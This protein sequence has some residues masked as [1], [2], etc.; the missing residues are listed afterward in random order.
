VTPQDVSIAIPTYKRES[1]L[2]S[3]IELLL[4]Q[5]PAELLIIDQTPE[6]QPPVEAALRHL[7]ATD[8]IRWLRLPRPSITRAMNTA[9][10]RAERP[11]VLFLD[12][13]VVPAPGLIHAHAS[14]YSSDE[15]WG[16]AG[17]VLQPGQEPEDVSYTTSDALG[18]SLGFPFNSTRPTFVRNGMAGNLSLRRER[19]LSVGGFDE[20]FAGVAYRYETEFC[21]RLCRAGGRIFFQPSA[22][23]RHLKFPSGGTRSYGD[24][25]TSPSPAHGV[26]DYYFA[27]RQGPSLSVIGYVLRRPLREVCT[28]FHLRHPWWMPVKLLGEMS[29]LLWAVVLVLRGPRYVETLSV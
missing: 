18:T 24:H 26:G 19:A 21:G 9:L 17:Q 20:N 13:D 22:S 5:N 2:V 16:V 3:T 23:L 8:R 11:I 1:V 28:R 4:D 7:E 29:A 15:I 14:G 6:H 27:L 25:L 10:Q 12:D